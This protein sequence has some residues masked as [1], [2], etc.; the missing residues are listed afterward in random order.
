MDWIGLGDF[1]YMRIACIVFLVPDGRKGLFLC[2]ALELTLH[3]LPYLTLRTE[4]LLPTHSLA[5]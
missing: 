2:T 4:P 1:C 5:P 3:T